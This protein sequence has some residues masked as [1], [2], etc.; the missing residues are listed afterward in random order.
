MTDDDVQQQS[1]PGAWQVVGTVLT[2][3]VVIGLGVLLWEEGLKDR[4]VAK[5][6]GQVAPGIYR[7][8]Q[9]S[10]HVIGPTLRDKG[11]DVIVSMNT[12][13]NDP[14]DLAEKAAARA[15]GVERYEFNLRGDGTGDPRM[16]VE[17]LTA[18][19]RAR[20]RGQTVL[21]HC[22]AGSERTGGMVGLYRVLFE[23]KSAGEAVPEM[24]RYKHDPGRNPDLI[25][26]LNAHVGEIAAALVDRGVLPSVPEPLP[27]FPMPD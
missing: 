2:I 18:L 22:H 10:G 27:R 17:G 14:D 26:Y 20:E 24:L 5:N 6:L 25:P 9:I 15:R 3:L 19:A 4:V 21:I 16:Y 23:G 1:S 11:I 8:G 12:E 7:S 13:E